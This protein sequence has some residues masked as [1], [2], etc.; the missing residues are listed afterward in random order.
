LP[1]LQ[2]TTTS[3]TS[4]PNPPHQPEPSGKTAVSQIPLPLADLLQVQ[5]TPAKTPNSSHPSPPLQEVLKIVNH[6]I[7]LAVISWTPS[8]TPLPSK[9]TESASP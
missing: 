4:L 9:P 7:G 3:P 5:S 2:G 8:S 6:T 1:K